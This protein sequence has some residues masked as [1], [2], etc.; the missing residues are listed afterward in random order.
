M[1]FLEGCGFIDLG[2]DLAGTGDNEGSTLRRAPW[3]LSPSTSGGVSFLLKNGEGG[4]VCDDW[5]ERMVAAGGPVG[6]RGVGIGSEFRVEEAGGT[7]GGSGSEWPLLVSCRWGRRM[8]ELGLLVA[9]RIEPGGQGI[10]FMKPFGQDAGGCCVGLCVGELLEQSGRSSL[11]RKGRLGFSDWPRRR[12]TLRFPFLDGGYSAL[13]DSRWCRCAASRA[14]GFQPR[15]RRATRNDI[16]GPGG[17]LGI[18]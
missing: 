18:I 5:D 16:S 9:L 7:Q 4:A 10:Q 13:P 12:P 17:F 3:N 1:W 14:P 8:R 15:L 11:T 6:R 2:I